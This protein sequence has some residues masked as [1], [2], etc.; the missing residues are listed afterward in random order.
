MLAEPFHLHVLSNP[1][2]A[3]PCHLPR[4]PVTGHS[5]HFQHSAGLI[6]GGGHLLTWL[7]FSS[8][9][10]LFCFRS[11]FDVIFLFGKEITQ[12]SRITAVVFLVPQQVYASGLEHVRSDISISGH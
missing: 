7:S 6:G 12:N 4:A 1:C 5:Q 9:H 10:Y 8:W 2:V 11:T 3:E